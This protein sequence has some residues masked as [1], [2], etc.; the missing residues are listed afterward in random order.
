MEIHQEDK[1]LMY[2]FL[3]MRLV[4]TGLKIVLQSDVKKG[5]LRVVFL[6]LHL[7]FL[8]LGLFMHMHRENSLLLKN[9]KRK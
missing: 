5:D 7:A 6:M 8:K 3:Q 9:C 1:K 4:D 2:Q